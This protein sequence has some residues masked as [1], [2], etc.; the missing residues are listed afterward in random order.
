METVSQ[1]HPNRIMEAT[2]MEHPTRVCVRYAAGIYAFADLKRGDTLADARRKL[3]P[4]IDRGLRCC[5]IYRDHA[6][7]LN[8]DGEEIGPLPHG[9]FRLPLRPLAS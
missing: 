2:L 1:N 4:Y 6:V 9:G 5:A 7:Y 3:L 8:P